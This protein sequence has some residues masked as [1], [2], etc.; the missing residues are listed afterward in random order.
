M[1]NLY[2]SLS[3][4]YNPSNLYLPLSTSYFQVT[5]TYSQL[6]STFKV[7]GTYPKFKLL[8]L[9][10][11][12]Q[13]QG[14]VHLLKIFQHGTGSI[15]ASRG[16]ANYNLL[17]GKTIFSLFILIL[18]FRLLVL[19]SNLFD[20]LTPVLVFPITLGQNLEIFDRLKFCKICNISRETGRF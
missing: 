8:Y 15:S 12:I 10:K 20:C 5:C 11:Y 16:F 19:S 13:V 14:Q 2:L 9:V 3:S 4:K 17:L 18:L 7:L 6:P 1:S